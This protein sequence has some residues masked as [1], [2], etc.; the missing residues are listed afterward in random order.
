MNR[1]LTTAL[2]FKDNIQKRGAEIMT[3]KKVVA[4]RKA[5]KQ[6]AAVE[7][8]TGRGRGTSNYGN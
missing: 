1:A 3:R 5:K 2:S 8:A 4:H 7:K 6:S